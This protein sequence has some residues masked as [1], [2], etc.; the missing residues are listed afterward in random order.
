MKYVLISLYN[1]S[2]TSSE[3]YQVFGWIGAAEN[4]LLGQELSRAAALDLA[5]SHGVPVVFG[6]SSKVGDLARTLSAEKTA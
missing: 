6:F 5:H 1:I 3:L 2:S 4:E